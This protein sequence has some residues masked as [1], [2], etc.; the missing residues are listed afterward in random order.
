MADAVAGALGETLAAIH[1]IAVTGYGHL[2]ERLHGATAT[3]G[4][5]FVDSLPLADALSAAAGD[6]RASALLRLPPRSSGATGRCSM[7]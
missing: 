7:P 1:G 3:F 2:E 6:P 5:W 4:E